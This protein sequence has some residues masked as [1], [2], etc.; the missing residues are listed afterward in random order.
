MQKEIYSTP[1]LESRNSKG[2]KK[3]WIGKVIEID[4]VIYTQTSW[5]SVKKDG[6]TS[7]TQF[8]EPYLVTP[9]NI[10][11]SNETTAVD[12]GISEINSEMHKLL[13]NGKG[14]FEEGNLPEGT[15]RQ[16]SLVVPMAAKKYSDMKSISFPAYAQPKLDG[17]R[18]LS[19][20]FKAWSRSI[21][22]FD[23]NIVKNLIIDEENFKQLGLGEEF[24][25]LVLDGE[26]ML[27]KRYSEWEAVINSDRLFCPLQEITTVAKDIEDPRIEFLEYYVFDVY[28]PDA[29][30]EFRKNILND[31]AKKGSYINDR[32]KFVT[33]SLVN[34]EEELFS[35][36]KNFVSQTYEG[37]MYR[38]LDGVYKEGPSRSS[39]LLK[40]K[41]FIDNEFV[42][43]DV[44]PGKGKEKDLATFVCQ[45]SN[46]KT[47]NV[48]PIGN[49]ELRRSYLTDREKLIGKSLTVRYQGLTKDLIPFIPKAISVRDYE[50]QG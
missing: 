28:I 35:L 36:H 43:V 7:K 32:I 48:S 27:P 19:D 4:G 39:D 31:I 41:D 50:I 8:S 11:K 12:Q 25:N 9:K 47:F 23:E 26:I 44:I 16:N 21:K 2:Q 24:S 15:L 46:N 40:I 42:I 17:F 3:F 22:I 38:S 29:T 13:N 34:N 5:W 1:T 10:G 45:N 49:E 33:A 20:R 6:E 30:Y 18:M 14:Y 37:T